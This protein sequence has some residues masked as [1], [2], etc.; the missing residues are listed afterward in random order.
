MKF[1]YTERNSIVSSTILKRKPELLEKLMKKSQDD[2]I[3]WHLDSPFYTLFLG[4]V[5][6]DDDRM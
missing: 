6:Q 1:N 4:K 2:G 3:V 5:P